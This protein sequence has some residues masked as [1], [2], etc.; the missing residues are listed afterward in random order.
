M[1]LTR[2][3]DRAR[4]KRLERTSKNATILNDSHENTDTSLDSETIS[5]TPQIEPNVHLS[6]LLRN[7]QLR[8]TLKLPQGWSNATE[9]S[10]C[11]KL[12]RISSAA[13]TSRQPVV[14]THC[15]TVKSDLKWL[16]YVHNNK[17]TPETCQSLKQFPVT[18]DIVTLENLLLEI[19]RLRVCCGHPDAQFIA[20][21]NAKKG[22]IVANGK[23]SAKIDS[24]A[25]VCLN[26]VSYPETVRT[27]K[28]ELL[29]TSVKCSSCKSYR[30]NLRAMYSAWCKRR[31]VEEMSDASGHSNERYLNT[32]EKKAKMQNLKD[33]SRA[34]EKQVKIFKEKIKEAIEAEGDTVEK[35]LS[36]DLLSILNTNTE[37]INRAYPEGSFPNLF[38]KEQLKAA[39]VKDP[40]Q[41]RWHPAIIKWCINLQLISS[42]AFHCIRSSGFLTLPSERTLR[43][44]THYFNKQPGF[45][46]DVN[47]YLQKEMNIQLLP[48]SKRYVALVIDE[49]KIKEDLVYDKKSGHIV[50]F[51]SLG[52]IGDI[53]SELEQKCKKDRSATP[54]VAQYILVIM[55]RGIFF[56]LDFPYAHF[57]TRGVT[58]DF[59]FPI[60][61]EAI[62]MIEGIGGKVISITADGASPNRKFFRMHGKGFVYK[63]FN[64]YADPREGRP[65]FFICDPPHL[66]KTT[67][68]CWS[69]SGFS[70][71]RL[72][73]V[74]DILRSF[75][76]NL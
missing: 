72:M 73:K 54:P 28:C 5:S 14:I 51:T 33:R 12:C 52:D 7:P 31:S 38:W 1:P 18:L 20:M 57:G 46:P 22:E 8:Q 62:R 68:N 65:V 16:L 32:P 67:R 56:K 69:H 4:E 61:W 66:I 47:L 6:D 23:V 55:V 49:M 25:S 41:V 59:L 40:R 11:M 74:S 9:D 43:D 3:K 75:S 36:S 58:A 24:H 64:P 71:T 76:L 19:D 39:S 10:V 63:A 35:S 53:L 50:G 70:G 15:L 42:A 21:V 45:H 29:S 13:T 48:E 34:A 30:A 27:E 44:Y 2:R 60:V 37:Q 17:L 26:G